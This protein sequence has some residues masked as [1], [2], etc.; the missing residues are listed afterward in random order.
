MHAFSL[1]VALCIVLGAAMSLGA[2]T[3]F[4]DGMLLGMCFPN[5]IGVYLLLPVVKEELVSFRKHVAEV[6]SA[7]PPAE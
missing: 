2:V 1:R 5:L 4:S 6:D 7:S 3:D